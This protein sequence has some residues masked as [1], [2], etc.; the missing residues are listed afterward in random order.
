MA[1]AGGEE[2]IVEAFVE[3]LEEEAQN[4]DRVHRAYL[5]QLR[6]MAEE[7]FAHVRPA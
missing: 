3:G 1:A 6:L 7:G 2:G 5:A 4:S